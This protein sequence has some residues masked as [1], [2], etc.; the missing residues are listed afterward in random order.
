MKIPN[1]KNALNNIQKACDKK[2]SKLYPAKVP[3]DI[4]ARY[5]QE[6]VFLNESELADDFELFR[7]L[8]EESVKCSTIITM[9]GTV[10]GSFIYYLLGNNCFNPLPVHYYC[11]KCGHYEQI[12]TH[13]FGIDLPEKTCPN[14]GNSIPADGYNIPVESAWGNDGR[15][16]ITFDYNVSSEFLPFAKRVLDSQYPDNCIVPWG[17]FQFDSVNP[18]PHPDTRAVGVALAGYAI[19]PTGSTIEDYPD[20]ISYLEDGSPCVTGGGWELEQNFLKPIRL[21]SLEYID[22]LIKLQRATGIYAN[23]ISDKEIH[24][25]T[26]SNIYNTTILNST[27]SSFFHELKPKTFRDMVSLESASHSTFSWQESDHFDLY[28]FNNM[29]SSDAFKKYP[30]FT[31]E[32]FFDYLIEEGVERKFAFDVSERIRKGHA[33]SSMCSDEFNTLQIPD[34]IKEVARNYMY[35][36]PRAHC[37]EYMLIYARIAYY[38]NIDSRAFSKIVFKKKG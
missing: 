36:F 12:N 18:L 37:I 16:I 15:K 22:I 26:W 11:P 7:L 2:I 13:L 14:C 6:L 21:F 32:D 3:D 19:L 4:V 35:I 25:I 33:N 38:A 29:A 1:I 23:E 10:M 9:R 30:C 20:L 34:D 31:R 28:S 27:T 24:E 17:M 8:S 5:Q